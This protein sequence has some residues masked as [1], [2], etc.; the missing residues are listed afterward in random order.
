MLTKS[1]RWEVHYDPYD[2][3]RVWVRTKDGGWLTVPWI[4]HH[5]GAAP[6]ADFTLR[7]VRR[8]LAE[9]GDDQGQ[10]AI[11][12][13]LDDLLTRA[14]TGPAPAPVPLASRRITARTRAAAVNPLRPVAAPSTATVEPD[15]AAE[16]S[17]SDAG[18]V[19]IPF[20]VFDA[21]KEA[22]RFW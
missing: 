21:H 10:D 7:H 16:A 3:S 8:L 20:G 17:D 12:R 6:F 14:G 9:R 18:A 4:H 2:L 11:T 5:R 13:A 1:G 19:V 15:D 22:E